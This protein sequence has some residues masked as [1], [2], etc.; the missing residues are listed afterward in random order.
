MTGAYSL[1]WRMQA[2]GKLL[3]NGALRLDGIGA[4]GLA[5]LLRETGMDSAEALERE[6]AERAEAAQTAIEAA[7]ARTEEEGR[8]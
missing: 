6:V 5:F 2:A 7:L 4:G 3:T 8:P 1:L